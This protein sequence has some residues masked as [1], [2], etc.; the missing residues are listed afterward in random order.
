M[1]GHNIRVKL[2]D[3]DQ[4]IGWKFNQYD[5]EGVPIRIEIGGREALKG[6]VSINLRNNKPDYTKSTL[7]YLAENIERLLEEVQTR[8][9]EKSKQFTK[10]NTRQADD[11]TQFKKIMNTTRGFIE[12]FW[13]EDKNCETKI[14]EETKATTRCLPQGAIEAN[15]ECIYC[16][17]SAKFRWFFGQSY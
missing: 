17:K 9:L 10:D 8:L 5:L 15:G 11:Y 14:K 7:E 16:E 6:E 3:S 12:A 13:C 1:R 2:D 4:S